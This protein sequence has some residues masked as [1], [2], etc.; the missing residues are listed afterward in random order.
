MEKTDCKAVNSSQTSKEQELEN[1]A[2]KN[3][4]NTLVTIASGSV[5][6]ALIVYDQILKMKKELKE[7]EVR[8]LNPLDSK[9]KEL[10]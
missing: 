1:I 3:R 5:I 6:V 9:S 2:L 8:I 7:N 4:Q 10:K